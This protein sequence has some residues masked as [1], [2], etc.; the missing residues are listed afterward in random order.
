LD[1]MKKSVIVYVALGIAIVSGLIFFQVS[2]ICYP[3]RVEI[4]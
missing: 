3:K 4:E 2:N 1:L